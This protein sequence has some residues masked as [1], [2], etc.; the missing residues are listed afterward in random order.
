MR[1]AQKDPQGWLVKQA[2][3]MMSYLRKGDRLFAWEDKPDSSKI[4]EWFCGE[5]RSK[6]RKE[7]PATLGEI[8]IL[9]S[10]YRPAWSSFDPKCDSRSI[11]IELSG[12][13]LAGLMENLLREE[14]EAMVVWDQER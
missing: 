11:V 6:L 1:K 9:G 10:S 4:W 14:D 5:I 8:A 13:V 2:Q 3:K 12:H 7:S